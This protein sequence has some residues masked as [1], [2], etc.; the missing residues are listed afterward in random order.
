LNKQSITTGMKARGLRY[1]DGASKAIRASAKTEAASAPQDIYIEPAR[2]TANAISLEHEGGYVVP[3][4]RNV[5]PVSP[6]EVAGT[7]L[8]AP[9]YLLAG[10]LSLLGAGCGGNEKKTEPGQPEQPEPVEYVEFPT[11]GGHMLAFEKSLYDSVN[12]SLM[13]I[14]Y[15]SRQVDNCVEVV[16]DD[17]GIDPP[18]DRIR[19]EYLSKGYT[20][21]CSETSSGCGGEGYLRINTSND[22]LAL[23]DREVNSGMRTLDD[24]CHPAIGPV[25]HE[26]SHALRNPPMF[27]SSEEGLAQMSQQLWVERLHLDRVSNVLVQGVFQQYRTVWNLGLEENEA[28]KDAMDPISS[29]RVKQIE[30]GTVVFSVNG[31]DLEPQPIGDCSFLEDKVIVCTGQSS[32]PDSIEVT[33]YDL[34]GKSDYRETRCGETGYDYVNVYNLPDRQLRKLYSA[35]HEYSEVDSKYVLHYC[36]WDRIRKA[37]GMT[38]VTNI[39]QSMFTVAEQDNGHCEEPFPF[40]ETVRQETG[41][42]EDAAHDLFNTFQVHEGAHACYPS[43]IVTYTDELERAR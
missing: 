40:F 38:A 6:K 5:K 41:L 13:T 42:S 29:I 14:A 21:F 30:N 33:I 43:E 2:E 17:L 1:E 16:K 27:I 3:I 22:A 39:L 4:A 28:V 7:V 25:V 36:F 35:G 31:G 26:L 10:L 9:V 34:A 24:R 12:P 8:A 19:V 18:K 23:I 20:N 11:S 32:E 37:G 15:L